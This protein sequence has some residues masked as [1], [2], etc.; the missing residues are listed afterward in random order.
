MS[1][2]RKRTDVD[3]SSL[4]A[5]LR[6]ATPDVALGSDWQPSLPLDWTRM[7]GRGKGD[8]FR[9]SQ[10]SR[11]RIRPLSNISD[12]CKVVPET[13]TTTPS[14]TTFDGR[15]IFC[16][17]D[18]DD[19]AWI[20]GYFVPKGSNKPWGMLAVR[21]EVDDCMACCMGENRRLSLTVYHRGYD[22]LSASDNVRNHGDD[23]NIRS[24]RNKRTSCCKI[25]GV[26]WTG[27]DM[28][29]LY[30]PH[31][32]DMQAEVLLTVSKDTN[33]NAYVIAWM[34]TRKSRAAPSPTSIYRRM[35]FYDTIVCRSTWYLFPFTNF[36]FDIISRIRRG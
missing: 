21:E 11:K 33:G 22:R 6:K 17:H 23:T 5:Q 4:S 30:H 31:S 19:P 12:I 16:L 10:Q 13:N 18:N 9:A 26:E 25:G 36:S 20:Q 1:T 34:C 3:S 35:C 7:G 28:I 15:A 14:N 24:K 32:V 29:A 8:S 27:G 2:K